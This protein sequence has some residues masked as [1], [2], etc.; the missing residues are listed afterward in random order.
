MD[1]WGARQVF[2]GFMLL[3]G[4]TAATTLSV[5]AGRALIRGEIDVRAALGMAGALIFMGVWLTFA[6]RLHLTGIYVNDRG[7]RL[8]HV[9]STRTL[10]W[11]RVTGF[12]ASPA[13]FLGE[14]TSRL[15]C[16]VRTTDGAFESAVQ[17]RSRR[18]GWRKEN[19][20]VLDAADFDQLLV[21][22]ADQRA[23]A[24]L[25]RGGVVSR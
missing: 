24:R 9:F 8:R 21:R 25:D 6:F 13:L 23:R 18:V 20:P 4:C 15:A 10:P 3:V 16:W 11:S 7:V 12:E 2:T 5:L 1:P 17:R 19:G 22:L 14:P